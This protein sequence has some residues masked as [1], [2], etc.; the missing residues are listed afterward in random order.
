MEENVL[1]TKTSE[2][3]QAC[4]IPGLSHGCTPE[5]N[6]FVHQSKAMNTSE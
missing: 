1:L 2:H 3:T 4:F 6:A 5:V